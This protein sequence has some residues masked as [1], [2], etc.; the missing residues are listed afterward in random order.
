MP[1]SLGKQQA[2]GI[3][4]QSTRGTGVTADYYI[5][6]TSFE[7][8]R[9]V[10]HENDE[11]A[12]GI[13]SQS[14]GIVV[15]RQLANPSLGGYLD[16]NSFG[17]IEY[18]GCDE[19]ETPVESGDAYIHEMKAGNKDTISDKFATINIVDPTLGDL[20]Y[21]DSIL[22]S[23]GL[24]FNMN[25]RIPFNAG[26]VSKYPASGNNTAAFVTPTYFMGKH[27]NIKIASTVSGLSGANALS[28]KNA[29][30]DRNYNVDNGDMAFNL[31][32]ENI[33]DHHQGEKSGS[34]KLA[35]F[36]ADNTYLGYMKNG[37]IYALQLSIIDTTKTVSAG[38]NPSIVYT[39]PAVSFKSTPG[40]DN[41]SIR[42][43]DL[44]LTIHYGADN[45]ATESYLYK[46][47]VT[48]L[49]P[50]YSAL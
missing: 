3:G 45:A 27:V 13:N 18:L 35:K 46:V 40:N 10:V 43:E 2:V 26:F 36:L 19:Y 24:S 38:V 21:I 39:F 42:P 48:N 12:L 29:S 31:G 22:N 1:N 8:G 28:I 50:D 30:L 5:K 47:M 25:G 32:N 33:S 9:D 6:K 16:L 37:D 41:P 20:D 7:D 11:S 23:L 14:S 15:P 4:R 49:V 34:L 17:L 44:D